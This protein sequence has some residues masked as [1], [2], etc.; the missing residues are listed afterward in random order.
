MSGTCSRLSNIKLNENSSTCKDKSGKA[1]SSIF[2]TSAANVLNNWRMASSWMLRRVALVRTNVL[3]E[4][5]AYFI[6]VTR[7][8]ELGT[9]LA[10]TSNWRTLWRNTKWERKLVWNSDWGCREEWGLQVVAWVCKW[11]DYKSKSQALVGGLDGA[12]KQ[13]R[14][15]EQRHQLSLGQVPK[16]LRSR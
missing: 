7:I 10:V 4:H 12:C 8:S 9:M 13:A 16:V 11:P 15:V 1:N 14:N 5:S 6:R 3:E 2:A